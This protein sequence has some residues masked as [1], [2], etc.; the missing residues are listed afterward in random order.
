MAARWGL[1]CSFD[2]D[3][4]PGRAE[5]GSESATTT[6]VIDAADLGTWTVIGRVLAAAGLAGL[7]GAQ[8]EWAGHEAGV[9]THALLG[10]ACS[11]FGVVS[12]GAFTAFIDDGTSNVRWDPSRIASYVVAGVGF[13]CGGVILKH[14]TEVKGLTTAA[15]LFVAAAVGLAT[16]LG[17]WAGAITAA[18]ASVALLMADIPLSRLS[19]HRN[20]HATRVEVAL[21]PGATASTALTD[22]VAIAGPH[23][24]RL[25]TSHRGNGDHEASITIELGEELP[26]ARLLRL[27]QALGA[28]EEV[29]TVACSPG[30]DLRADEALSE[31]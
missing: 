27:L 9:R 12:V 2:T 13:L 7:I 29:A 3:R 10:L 20:K 18:V 30:L 19:R 24:S 21:L 25:S 6:F 5:T 8:R 31:A 14:G 1:T 11:L 4:W 26:Q 15:S 28:R 22:V 17:F 23:V 16:G